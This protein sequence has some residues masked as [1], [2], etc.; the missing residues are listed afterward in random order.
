[1]LKLDE[2]KLPTAHIWKVTA[3]Q[4]INT[5]LENNLPFSFEN[6]Y[7]STHAPYMKCISSLE[8]NE[9]ILQFIFKQID[10]TRTQ[11]VSATIEVLANLMS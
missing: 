10:N 5:A 3:L 1:M 8:A 4:L 9:E 7:F 2:K 11:I 6:D